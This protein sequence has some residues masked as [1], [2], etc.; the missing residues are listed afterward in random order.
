MAWP[1]SR[2]RKNTG[3]Q[4]KYAQAVDDRGW[5]RIFD[6]SPGAWQQHAPYDTEESVLA[7]PTVFACTTLISGDIGKLRPTVQKEK[8]GIWERSSHRF[9]KLL[10]KPNNYQTHVQ[11]VEAWINSKLNHGNTYV[12]KTGPSRMYDELHI[13]DPLKVTPLI[14]DNGDVFYRIN[15]DQLVPF[16]HADDE[17]IVVPASEII[18]DRF[19]CLY[20]PLVGLSPIFAAGTAATMGLTAQQNNKYFFKNSSNPGGVLTAPGAISDSTATRLKEYF[21]A[22][23]SGKNSGRIAVAGDGLSYESFRMSSVDAQM[24]E[25]LGWNDEKICAV[26]HVPGYMVSVGQ[27][28][29]HNNIEALIQQYYSQCLQTLIEGM[30]VCLDDGLGIEE[31]FRVQLDLDGLFRMDGATLIKTLAEGV[32]GSIYT[33]NEARK[34]QNLKPLTGGDTVYMQQQNYSLEALSERDGDNPLGKGAP[35][36]APAPT[37]EQLEQQNNFMAYLLQKELESG[38]QTA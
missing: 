26:Y 21:E 22:K 7:Y 24:I 18:H 3:K 27:Q 11:F 37:D 20:H 10:K 32:K 14:A 36:P 17:Q 25:T 1:F 4:D 30:E 9:A 15:R 34:R 5:T 16:N 33:P 31:G 35:P 38:Y 29:T 12:L 28:P 8:D 6:W 13:L 19:N 2:S 23:F